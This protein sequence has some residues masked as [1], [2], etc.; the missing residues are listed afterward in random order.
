[1]SYP[2]LTGEPNFV[3][4]GVSAVFGLLIII[5]VY[6]IMKTCN[7]VEYSILVKYGNCLYKCYI[8]YLG[9][10]IKLTN[11]LIN[12]LYSFYKKN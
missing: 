7:L 1:M 9:H 4:I 11:I 12:K 3:L 8:G 2:M 5:I 10:F 6:Y